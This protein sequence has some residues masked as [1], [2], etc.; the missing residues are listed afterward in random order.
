MAKSPA[1]YVV[2]K[3]GK[4][5]LFQRKIPK[6]IIDKLSL[7]SGTVYQRALS[8]TLGCSDAELNKALARSHTCDYFTCNNRQ[9]SK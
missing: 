6:K 3:N 4:D 7:K 8:L 2:I 9:I 1:K 5:L